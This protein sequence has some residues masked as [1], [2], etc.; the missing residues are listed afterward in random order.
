M[1][2]RCPRCGKNNYGDLDKC[3]FCGSPLKFVPGQDIPDISEEDIQEKMSSINIKRI[4]NPLTIGVGGGTMLVGAALVVILYLVV[5]IALF[6]P[7]SVEPKY[8]GAWHYNVPGGE[9]YIFGEITRVVSVSE[10][11]WD[12][13]SNHGYYNH[14]AY[15]ING[16]GVDH[17]KDALNQQDVGREP[18]T[19]IYSE[20]DLGENGDYIL[21]KVKSEP[22]FFMERRAVD[23]GKIWWGGSGF[24]SGWIFAF[25]GILVFLAGAG[26]L[27]YGFIG[28]KDTSI[29]R[30]L[31]EDAEFRK[32][33]IAL[34]QSARMAAMKQQQNTQWQQM[35]GQ[36]AAPEQQVPGG[37]PPPPIQ[38]AGAQG[39]PLQPPVVQGQT[40]PIP[41]PVG[42]PG[43]QVPQGQPVP[44][45]PPMGA[46]A[47]QM[48]VAPPQ[49]QMDAPAV[50]LPQT[51]P[52]AP[53][54]PPASS[55]GVNTG[56][57]PPGA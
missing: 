38:Q 46:P 57:N 16:D 5:M 47:V 48:P 9:E 24:M 11:E 39:E 21:V 20:R 45:A 18:H 28:K 32:Q 19:W 37:Q 55:Q 49:A 34:M 36:P 14:T 40:A 6:S 51:P 29:D 1:T 56:Y 54:T 3:S 50:Q 42:V 27:I 17:R 52:P 22:N 8:D 12:A 26:M 15:E 43:G 2:I 7:D 35:E 30:L 23:T 10:S 53:A 31:E 33:Q 25:P 4:R 44:A 41:Q 13:G